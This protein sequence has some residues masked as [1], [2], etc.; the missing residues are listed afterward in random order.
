[1]REF[2]VARGQLIALISALG[3]SGIHISAARQYAP[4]EL[5][6]LRGR[7]DFRGEAIRLAPVTAQRFSASE[8]NVRTDSHGDFG[9][10]FA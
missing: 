8:A 9:W 7:W 5:K 2:D 1:V 4:H 6:V 3:K 10:L